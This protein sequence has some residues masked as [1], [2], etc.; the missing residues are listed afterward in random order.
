MHDRDNDSTKWWQAPAE[1]EIRPSWRNVAPMPSRRSLKEHFLLLAIVA[2]ASAAWVRMEPESEPRTGLEPGDLAIHGVKLG[3]TLEQIERLH[4][5][6]HEVRPGMMGWGIGPEPFLR[7]T[8]DPGGR[9]DFLSGHALEV[10]G[11]R[12]LTPKMTPQTWIPLFGN[13]QMERHR[14]AHCAFMPIALQVYRYDSLDLTITAKP[15]G[16]FWQSKALA[17]DFTLSKRPLEACPEIVGPLPQ[18]TLSEEVRS[19]LAEDPTMFVK[20]RF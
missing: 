1:P 4:G 6:A 5:E 12:H 7:A 13:G 18:E 20:V 8:F 16:H 19:L 11:G 3:W 10:D 2:V 15:Q 17:K 14:V 9:A